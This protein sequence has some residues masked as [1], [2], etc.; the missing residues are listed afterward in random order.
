M[1]RSAEVIRP[2]GVSSSM[3]SARAP[4]ICADAIESSMNCATAGLIEP[5]ILISSTQG[6]RSITASALGVALLAAKANDATV[7]ASAASA[8]GLAIDR[9]D[10][11]T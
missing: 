2:P 5:S 10:P 7:I 11:I 3:I 8:S 4:P 9:E 6:R 1:M